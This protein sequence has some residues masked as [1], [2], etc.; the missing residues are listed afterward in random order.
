MVDLL[1]LAVVSHQC[2]TFGGRTFS[3]RPCGAL[4]CSF[5]MVALVLRAEDAAVVLVIS[6]R[7]MGWTTMFGHKRICLL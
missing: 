2:E 5:F 7:A 1:E 6:S 4:L 3:V